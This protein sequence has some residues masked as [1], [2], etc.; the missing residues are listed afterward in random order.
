MLCKARIGVSVRTIRS[1]LYRCWKFW[2]ILDSF[3]GKHP[4]IASLLAQRLSLCRYSFILVIELNYR[5]VF[6]WETLNINWL[7]FS[8]YVYLSEN[9]LFKK[10]QSRRHF[11]SAQSWWLGLY[12]LSLKFF[13]WISQF[14][15]GISESFLKIIKIK[16]L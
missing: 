8:S 2:W 5:A 14:A 12:K 13:L 9:D 7:C 10:W 6:S 4:F 1:S 11:F 15:G 16:N 3:D